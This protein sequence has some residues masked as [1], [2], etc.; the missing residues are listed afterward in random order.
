MPQPAL[1]HLIRTFAKIGLLSFGG[2][3]AQIGVMHRELVDRLGW[4][5]EQQFT[6]ALSFAMLLPGP[7][8]M[9]LC[10]YAGWRMRGTVGG[11]I[12]GAL[13]VL[14][15]AV[16]MAALSLAYLRWGDLPG[17][18]TAFM[19]IK[20]AVIVVVATALARLGRKVLTTWR[21]RA[22]AAA[23]F[24]ALALFAL[25]FPLVVVVAAAVGTAFGTGEREASPAPAR[26]GAS[27]RTATL[28]TAL[29]LAP[30]AVLWLIGA[31]QLADITA[32]FSRLAI[33]SFGGA[34]AALAWM[35]QALV[36][37]QG[38]LTPDQMVDGLGLAETTP[39]PLILVTQFAGM[40]AAAPMGIGASLT[41]GALTLWAIFAPCF[42]LVFTL[43]PHLD[44]LTAQPRLAAALESVSSAIVGVIAALALYFARNFFFETRRLSLE[45][46]SISALALTGAA[47]LLLSLLRLPLPVALVGL[48]GAGWLL[49]VTL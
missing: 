25:P 7:E 19:G 9:Q 4:L 38:W 20:A 18:E 13:F 12:A 40:V 15:G 28:W 46:L 33:F 14:P 23:A 44:R 41:A 34:Y 36:E 10:T 3:V 22:L 43:A 47:V 6:R 32:F 21:A 39:G 48:A 8:A 11:L 35:A 17:V 45:T 16:F 30:L 49:G 29:W 37:T 31:T 42:G 1:A 5:T 2:P 26:L 27:L 24:V